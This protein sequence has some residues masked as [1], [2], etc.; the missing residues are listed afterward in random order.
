MENNKNIEKAVVEMDKF[1]QDKFN[2]I[3]LQEIEVEKNI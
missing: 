2:V 1:L 3:C